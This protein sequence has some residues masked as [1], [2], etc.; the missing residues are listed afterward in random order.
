MG[1]RGRRRGTNIDSQCVWSNGRPAKVTAV[2][3]TKICPKLYVNV[4]SCPGK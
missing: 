1:R 4:T 3:V 2:K